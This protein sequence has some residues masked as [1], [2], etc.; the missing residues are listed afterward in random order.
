MKSQS[1]QHSVLY[2]DTALDQAQIKAFENEL[3]ILM[4]TY[5]LKVRSSKENPQKIGDIHR[6][7]SNIFGDLIPS[8]KTLA[9]TLEL[10]TRLSD[11]AQKDDLASLQ[12]SSIFQLT[13]AGKI[14]AVTPKGKKQKSYYFDPIIDE[15]NLDMICGSVIS[16]RYLSE[17]NRDFLVKSLHIL[18]ADATDRTDL[19]DT[20]QTALPKRPALQKK[21]SFL[22]HVTILYQAILDRCQVEL[23]YA[24]YKVDPDK[25]FSQLELASISPEAKL[26]NPYAL[27]WNHG[28]YYLIATYDGGEKPYHFRIDRIQKVSVAKDPEDARKNK[29]REKIPPA[30]KPY[31]KKNR[32]DEKR[33]TADYSNMWGLHSKSPVIDCTLD[34]PENMLGNVIDYFGKEKIQICG[35]NAGSEIQNKFIKP[36]SGI[37]QI[38]V[39]EV[40]YDNILLFCLEHHYCITVKKPDEL[41]CDIKKELASSLGRYCS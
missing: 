16:N 6:E 2:N 3:W 11:L 8:Q 40:N 24:A 31:F 34:C 35:Q 15:G 18:N 41:V 38:K 32:L 27:V 39:K 20:L 33:Y 13:L 1:R 5:I 22:E 25:A 19:I 30:L 29:E 26:V 21:I 37:C 23:S 36:D 28:Q 9:R 12:L 10:I 7:L 14:I 4:I 17:Q